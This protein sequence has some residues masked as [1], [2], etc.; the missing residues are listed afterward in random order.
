MSKAVKAYK[1]WGLKSGE[2]YIADSDWTKS[3]AL[4]CKNWKH[5]KIV[6]VEIREI[7]KGRKK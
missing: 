2:R 7:R 4:Y 6:R 1:A 3:D 5:E